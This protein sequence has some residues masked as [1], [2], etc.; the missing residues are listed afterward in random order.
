MAIV[1]IASTAATAQK[2]DDAKTMLTLSQFKM[3]KEKLDKAMAVPKEAA[4]PEIYIAKATIYGALISDSSFAAQADQLANDAE[5]AYAKYLEMDPKMS[6]VKDPIYVNATIYQY[7]YFYNTGYKIYQAK[8]FGKAG[9]YFAKAIE[10]SNFISKNELAKLNFDTT[11]YTLA[12]DAY[13]RDKQE[14]K[15][16][17]YF[18]ALADKKIGGDDFMFLYS[19]LMVH[20]FDKNVSDSFNYYRNVGKELYPKKDYFDYT[21]ADFILDMKDETAKSQRLDALIAANPNDLKLQ[22]TYGLVLFDKLSKE[23]ANSLPNYAELEQKMMNMLIEGAKIGPSNEAKDY[24]YM[25]NFYL[26]K[27]IGI[28]EKLKGVS[29]EV[30]AFNAANKPKDPKGKMPPVPKELLD[31]RAALNKTYDELLD[32]ALPYLERSAEAFGKMPT[33]TSLEKNNF[34]KKAVDQ[35]SVIYGDKKNASKVPADKAKFEAA[36]KKWNAVYSSIH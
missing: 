14:A 31:K 5:A 1:W 11:L 30:K 3:A 17:P 32:K 29:E 10:K 15:A 8:D 35:V 7:Q 19:F 16:T 21:E 12:G 33:L 4:K 36:E 18:K 24:F 27:G 2:L 28:T 20:Y 25:G 22:E 26:N 6:L 13:Q 23:E 34:Y 9:N